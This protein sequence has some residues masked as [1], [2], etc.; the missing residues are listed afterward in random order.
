MKILF[1]Q[2]T[3]D[4]QGHYGVYT[5]NL[6]QSM[7]ATNEVTLVTNTISPHKYLKTEP[8][9]TVIEVEKERCG[10]QKY[11]QF[12]ATKPWLYTFR[13][14]YNSWF[15]FKRALTIA[16]EQKVD[17]IQVSDVEFSVLS[18]ALFLFGR[19]IPPVCVLLH[20]ANFSYTKYDGPAFMRVYKV[21]QREFFKF[22]FGRWVK[23]IVSLGEY[24]LTQLKEQLSLAPTFPIRTIHD[25]ADSPE[26][27]VEPQVARAALEIEYTGTLLLF[28]GMLRKDKGI[29]VLFEALS[30][31]QT[32]EC[33][34]LFA[35][36]LFDYTEEQIHDLVKKFHIQ[37]KVI[38]RLGYIPSDDVPLYFFASDCLVLPYRSSYAGGSGPLLK[39]AAVYKLPVIVSNVSEMGYLVDHYDMG[40]TVEPENAQALASRLD[41]FLSLSEGRCRE[42]GENGRK[43]SNTWKKMGQEYC[44]FFSFLVK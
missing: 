31:M 14:L 43:V 32:R 27:A 12:R 5:T 6:C 2:P 44:D 16:R 3:G 15:I 28:F 37:D 7:A 22:T 11:E 34:L 8:L 40:L 35:G 41:E 24:H 26:I 25:G 13:Y 29:E 20:A 1:V 4:R 21:L 18:A 19:G 10:F 39:E 33:R 36:S 17:I 42:M 9:F 30:R 38:L 23:G